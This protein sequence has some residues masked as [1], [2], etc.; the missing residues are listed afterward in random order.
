MQLKLWP[1]ESSR[2]NFCVMYP[3]FHPSVGSALAAIP[4]W[5]RTGL[6]RD[7]FSAGFLVYDELRICVNLCTKCFCLSRRI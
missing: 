5:D 1:R 4:A 7:H 3:G 2:R 6:N